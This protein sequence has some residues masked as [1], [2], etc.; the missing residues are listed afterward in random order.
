MNPP[1]RAPTASERLSDPAVQAALDLAWIDS[2]A[3]Q[4]PQ[5]RDE[6]G[7]WIYLDI[8]TGRIKVVRAARGVQNEIDLSTP[9]PSLDSVVVGKFHT[10]P[11]PA[12]QGWVTGPSPTDLV[13]AAHHGV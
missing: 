2:Q 1:T 4:P 5:I 12:S 8:F 10:H 9:P 7:G 6:E 13:V 11:N 3:G